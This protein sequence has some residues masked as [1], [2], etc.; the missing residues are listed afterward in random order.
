MEVQERKLLS[1]VPVLRKRE[2]RQFHVVVVQR[3]RR[4]VQKSM[5]HAAKL[6]CYLSKPIAFLPFSLPSP[7][8]LRKLHIISITKKDKNNLNNSFL[9]QSLIQGDGVLLQFV[10]I[11]ALCNTCRNL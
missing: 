3:R 5:M 6:L 9:P 8:F 7:C 4:N 11:T 2:I 10:I 1:F